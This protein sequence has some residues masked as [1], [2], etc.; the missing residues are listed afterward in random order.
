MPR[1]SQNLT[2]AVTVF[3]STTIAFSTLAYLAVM[4]RPREQFFQIYVLGETGRAERYYPS[5]NPDIRVGEVVRWRVG[6]ANFMGSI[7]YVAIRVK[8]GNSTIE[9]PDEANLVPSPAPVLLEFKKI[10]MSDETWE[11]ALIWAIKEIVVS[12]NVIAPTILDINGMNVRNGQV[13]ALAGH[14]FRLF[15]ELWTF[16]PQTKTFTFGWKTL[17]E[18]RIAWLQLWFNATSSAVR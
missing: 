8:L 2:R 9:T 12:G 5:N 17:K 18:S 16:D 13:S 4:P 7:Q 11:F 10:L 3:L 6:V 14:N 1:L 15:F